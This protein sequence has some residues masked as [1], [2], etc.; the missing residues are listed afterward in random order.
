MLEA[1]ENDYEFL[2]KGD[3]FSLDM[4]EAYIAYKREVEVDPMRMRPHP[5]EFTL[6]Y[7]A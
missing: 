2:L 7:D 1:L 3:V 4:L 6:Y 5:Y